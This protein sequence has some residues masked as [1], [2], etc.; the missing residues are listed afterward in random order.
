VFVDVTAHVQRS[1]SGSYTVANVQTATGEDRHA[2]WGL[3]VAYESAGD[4]PR[5]LT[6]FDGLQSFTQGT[7]TLTIPVSNFFNSAISVD[8]RY[9]SDK[10]PD[11]V[12]QLGFDAKPIGINGVLANGGRARTSG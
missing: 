8:G 11:Y 4:P 2:G 7:R 5:D 6:V 9:R 3:M 12:N 10:N 1:G